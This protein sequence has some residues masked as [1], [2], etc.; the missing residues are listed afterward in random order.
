LI[1]G[2]T[3]TIAVNAA[4]TDIWVIT[5]RQYPVKSLPNVRLIELDTPARIEAE[6]AAQLP[7]DPDRAAEIAQQRLKD[8]GAMLQ[9][10]LVTAYQGIVDAWSLGVTKIPAV[11]VDRRYVV[12]GDSDVTH[13]LSLIEKHRNSHP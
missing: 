11:V 3:L 8:G 4:A 7:S 2:A 12:Y 6:L 1:L 10:R 9:Q 5:D 13:A